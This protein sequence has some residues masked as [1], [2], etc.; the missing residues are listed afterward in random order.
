M[1]TEQ[2]HILTTGGLGYIGSH[3]VV[4]LLNSGYQVSIIDNLDN[5]CLEVLNRIKQLTGILPD[6]YQGDV[7]DSGFLDT[8]FRDNH[9][10]AVIH[11]A[12]LKAVGESVEKPELYYDVNVVG[13]LRLI[14]VML[15]HNVNKIV[16]SSSATVYGEPEQLPITEKARLQCCSPYGKTKLSVEEMLGSS[17]DAHPQL[18]VGTLRY[19]NPIGAHPSAT[20]GEA[21][22]ETPNNLMPYVT[23]VAIGRRPFLQIWGNDYNTPD[24]TGVRDYIHVVDLAHAHIKTLCYLDTN[25]GYNVWNIGVGRGY[26]V[27]DV[28]KSFEKENNIEVPYKIRPR[29]AGDVESCYACPDKA[30]TELGWKAKF[31]LTEMVRDSWNWQKQNPD[32]YQ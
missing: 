22:Q 19:F 11:L 5:S 25:N 7:R 12:G 28:I 16:F 32:G 8:V 17:A 27:L 6:F 30:L 14:E 9:I 3:T 21:P 2:Q 31:Q 20:M 15:T 18:G 29:R 24:G 26:S 1:Q 23:Q 10:D 13:S 4:E